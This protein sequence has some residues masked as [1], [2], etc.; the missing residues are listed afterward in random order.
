MSHFFTYNAGEPDNA[1]YIS[2]APVGSGQVFKAGRIKITLTPA[3]NGATAASGYQALVKLLTL[4]ADPAGIAPAIDLPASY[5]RAEVLTLSTTS[6]G[7][8]TFEIGQ[9]HQKGWNPD[10]QGAKFYTH[11]IVQAKF[12]DDNDRCMLRFDID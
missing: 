4:D 2:L 10:A 11:A 5:D 1:K 12:V 7:V 3:A 6:G 9:P 8:Q